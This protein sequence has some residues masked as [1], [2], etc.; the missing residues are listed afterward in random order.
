MGKCWAWF[1][2]AC[3]HLR[4][5]R[6]NPRQAVVLRSPETTRSSN[7]GGR[8][9][10]QHPA[11]V[12]KKWWVTGWLMS[13][14]NEQERKQVTAA[15]EFVLCIS[16]SSEKTEWKKRGFP[17]DPSVA[18]SYFAWWGWKY[19]RNAC[20]FCQDAWQEVTISECKECES[21]FGS[22]EVTSD[23]SGLNITIN[24]K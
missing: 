5:T 7:T 6:Q 14:S 4:V 22:S 19:Y 3:H 20:H 13:V 9:T 10:R 18:F 16:L 8:T 17:D 23:I 21:G 2:F 24:I 1:A 11:R 15:G 12:W